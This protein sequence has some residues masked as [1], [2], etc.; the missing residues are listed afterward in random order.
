MKPDEIGVELGFSDPVFREKF[1]KE[2][3]KDIEEDL[4][5]AASTWAHYIFPSTRLIRFRNPQLTLCASLFPW[6]GGYRL[7]TAALER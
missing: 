5:N 7:P 6:V 2:T 1:K 4:S 3:G